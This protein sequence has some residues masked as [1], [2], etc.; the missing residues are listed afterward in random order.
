MFYQLEHIG[1]IEGFK[2]ERGENFNYPPH[3]H[4]SFEL[5]LADAGEMTVTV[6]RNEYTL[7]QGDA[8]LIFPNQVHALH[9]VSSR[10]T[11]FIFSPRI[12]QA[13]SAEYTGSR[14]RS[15]A[16][17]LLAQAPHALHPLSEDDS[18]S[19]RK[20][21]LYSVCALLEQQT[22]FYKVEL[23]KQDLLLRILSYVEQ[24]FQ[25]ECSLITLAA[26]V[27]YNPEYISRFF[28]KKMGIGYNQYLNARRLN[29]AAH[30]LTNTDN[31]CL[32]CALESGYTSLRSFNRNFKKQFGLPPQEYKNHSTRAE[33]K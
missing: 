18:K 13:F 5:I 10:H 30:L 6:D 19:A 28:K 22:E 20:G 15:D 27:G 23:D 14:P 16:V 21:T 26:E 3:L 4:G 8:A 11:L 32:Y 24:H 31:T 12:I 33:T 25:G 17:S 7:K 1:T 9:S 2:K 29:H